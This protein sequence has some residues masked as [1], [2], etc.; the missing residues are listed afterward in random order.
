MKFYVATKFENLEAARDTMIELVQHGHE[1]T[2][3]WTTYQQESPSA[4][5][6]DINGVIDADALIVLMEKDLPYQGTLFEIGC[7]LGQHIPVY[8][9]GHAPMTQT[10]FI[11]FH[12]LV[13]NVDSLQ[14]VLDHVNN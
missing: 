1:I 6:D 11:R 12:P 3:D 9:I 10:L 13:T 5:V 8:V 2:H 7:A 4:A 14:E